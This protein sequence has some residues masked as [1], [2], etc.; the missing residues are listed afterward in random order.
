M[1]RFR[2]VSL[3]DWWMVSWWLSP[4]GSFLWQGFLAGV[5]M[6]MSRLLLIVPR[7]KFSTSRLI[8]IIQWG[9]S[10]RRGEADIDCT[11]EE[12]PVPYNEAHFDCAQ[13]EVLYVEAVIDCTKEEVLYIEADIDCTNEEVLYVEARLI[14][15]VPRRKFL[16][17]RK[18]LWWS[19]SW[20]NSRW[21]LC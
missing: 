16:F 14:L 3:T 2:E 19:S 18:F 13:E 5:P 17:R 6:L 11:K 4:G 10:L 8:L 12:I 21:S 7:R 1:F 9:S 15:T 20:L